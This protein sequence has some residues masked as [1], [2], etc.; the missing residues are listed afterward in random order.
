MDP[1][2]LDFEGVAEK[3]VLEGETTGITGDLPGGVESSLQSIVVHDRGISIVVH[4]WGI[5]SRRVTDF[6]VR[7]G[8]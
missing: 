8:P 7:A 4:D 6:E 3:K 2:G 5:E 1:L